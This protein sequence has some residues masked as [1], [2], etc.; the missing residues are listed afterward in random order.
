ML[1]GHLWDKH[2]PGEAVRA[3]GSQVTWQSSSEGMDRLRACRKKWYC[4]RVFGVSLFTRL[5]ASRDHRG[6]R[7]TLFLAGISWKEKV[8]DLRLK[9]AERSI[10]WFVVTAL[11][12]IACEY[13]GSTAEALPDLLLGPLGVCVFLPFSS[14]NGEAVCSSV[15]KSES[16]C[17][18]TQGRKHSRWAVHSQGLLANPCVMPA[19]GLTV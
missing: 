2:V 3:H 5:L 12:E 8:A 17:Q 14:L 13:S 16:R 10:A 9:M 7:S 6:V 4:V 18:L 19:S 1:R 11:D 15:L